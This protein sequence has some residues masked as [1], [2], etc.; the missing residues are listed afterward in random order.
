M[1]NWLKDIELTPEAATVR[2][3][4]SAGEFVHLQGAIENLSIVTKRPI[5][6]VANRLLVGIREITDGEGMMTFLDLLTD[7][8]EENL[9]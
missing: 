4:L 3:Q 7:I 6:E 8:A 9:K 1:I 2:A 5:A